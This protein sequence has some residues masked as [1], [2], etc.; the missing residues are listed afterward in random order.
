M[1][2]LRRKFT[3]CN[4]KASTSI[5]LLAISL[6][7]SPMDPVYA[8]TRSRT[9]PPP[10]PAEPSI[11]ISGISLLNQKTVTYSCEDGVQFPV[12]YVNTEDGQSFAVLPVDG[13]NRLFVSLI[14]GSGVRYGSGVYVWWSKGEQATLWNSQN[15]RRPALHGTC[16]SSE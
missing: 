1:N 4:F 8:A 10:A 7:A 9:A 2:I 14:S 6:F 3:T 11:T 5:S 16:S 13:K 15:T 12:T